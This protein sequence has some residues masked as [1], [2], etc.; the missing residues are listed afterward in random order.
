MTR[1]NVIAAKPSRFLRKIALGVAALAAIAFGAA[2][3]SEQAAAD[4]AKTEKGV[5]LELFTSQ[6]CYSCPPADKLLGQLA[7]QKGVVGLS[8]NVDYWDYLG[9]KDRLAQKAYT[10]RQYGY[11]KTQ[12]KRAP[13]TPQLVVHGATSLVGSDR[14]GVARALRSVKK[15]DGF[16]VELRRDGQTLSIALAKTGSSDDCVVMIAPYVKAVRQK[17]DTGENG[18]KSLV[19][20]NAAIEV[21]QLGEFSGGEASFSAPIPDG[22]DGVA[23]WVQRS[24]ANGPFGE[25]LTAAKLEFAVSEASAQ[26][27][28]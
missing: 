10:L 25:V 13:F 4:S 27:F 7:S 17:I 6:G 8:L 1:Q 11:V 21:R 2:L 12:R 22:A 23:V 5:L 24:T 19:Y 15:D 20:H 3:T 14:A 26:S 16:D 9:W 18:G 28:R